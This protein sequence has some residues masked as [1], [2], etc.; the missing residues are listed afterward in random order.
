MPERWKSLFSTGKSHMKQGF[1]RKLFRQ[2]PPWA[3]HLHP[4]CQLILVIPSKFVLT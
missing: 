2:K 3:L 4:F 1:G